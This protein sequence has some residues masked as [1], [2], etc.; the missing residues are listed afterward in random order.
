VGQFSFFTVDNA[1]SDSTQAK[2]NSSPAYN[3]F[4]CYKS[5]YKSPTGGHHEMGLS[6]PYPSTYPSDAAPSTAY[7]PASDPDCA[8]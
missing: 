3:A 1:N 6:R 2:T 4:K 8:D 5:Y 7:S